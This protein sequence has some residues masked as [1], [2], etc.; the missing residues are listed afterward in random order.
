MNQYKNKYSKQ[1]TLSSNDIRRLRIQEQQNANE[2]RER[3]KKLGLD[4]RYIPIETPENDKYHYPQEE[5]LSPNQ[6]L[7]NE[8][9][10]K[11]KKTK[12]LLKRAKEL[13]KY[14]PDYTES[15]IQMNAS[16]NPISFEK[17]LI[18]A[19]ERAEKEK[20]YY[21]GGKRKTNKRKLNKKKQTKKRKTLKKN[22]KSKKSRRN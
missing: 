7:S 8:I 15:D 9:R 4:K 12:E 10:K 11:D 14:M 16:A 5:R 22:K 21:R 6:Q 19:Q 18:K 13:K 17:T 1:K 3:E 2:W 20:N